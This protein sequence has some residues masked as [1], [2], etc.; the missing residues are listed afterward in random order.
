M[1]T[2][3]GFKMK[4]V[5]ILEIRELSQLE[6]LDSDISIIEEFKSMK[7]QGLEFY[8]RF[9]E[10]DNIVQTDNAKGILLN[11]YSF[12]T[13]EYENNIFELRYLAEEQS[14]YDYSFNSDEIYNQ[15]VE[16]VHNKILEEK[17]IEL[18]DIVY[19]IESVYDD[20]VH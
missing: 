4:E 1:K 20:L 10:Y 9:D 3:K 12:D 16:S 6:A 19:I 18:S 2:N 15:Y 8:V 7:K 11:S 13:A 17:T 5:K 14:D